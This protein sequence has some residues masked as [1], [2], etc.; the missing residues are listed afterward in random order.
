MAV[1]LKVKAVLNQSESN[2]PEK[3]LNLQF[4]TKNST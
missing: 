1:T 2:N 3:D 4:D